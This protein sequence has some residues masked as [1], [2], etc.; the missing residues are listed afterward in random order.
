M[1]PPCMR[2]N[3]VGGGGGGYYTGLAWEGA[4]MMPLQ[5]NNL[6]IQP[7]RTGSGRRNPAAQ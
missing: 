7:V 1:S 2:S 4:V 3:A 5:A 6:P